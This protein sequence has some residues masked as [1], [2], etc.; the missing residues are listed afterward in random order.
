M[1]ISTLSRMYPGRLL[2]GIGL[3]LPVW[4]E[5]MGLRPRSDLT[6]MRECVTSV[7][8]LLD[9]EEVDGD[10]RSFD[11]HGVRLSYPTTE[12]VPLYMGVIGPKMLRLS[13]EIADGTVVSVLASPEYVTWTREQ[14][15]A[16]Q[17]AAG[18]NDAHPM[19]V[20]AMFSVDRAGTKAKEAIRPVTAFYLH[21]MPENALTDVYGIA[22]EAA[23][24]AAQGFDAVLEGMPDQW[25]EDLVI[26][27]DL[28]ECA[29]KIRR[30]LEAGADSVVLFPTPPEQ[31]R[32]LVELAAAEI[33]PRL[34][35]G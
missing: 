34:E 27:G 14:I 3:G 29:A 31:A 16:G 10:G 20:F 12:R 13:G 1:E 9:G 2:P 30:L 35:E 17:A 4:I 6:A 21:A 33:L 23:A 25:I 28:E 22:E 18:R 5:Q 15:A 26:A 19:A 32:E 8:R 11:F 7:R 24:L